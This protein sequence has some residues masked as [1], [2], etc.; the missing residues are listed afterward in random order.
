MAGN[1]WEWTGDWYQ[2]YPGS[3]ASSQFF[4]ERFRVTRGGGW[5]DEE[6]Q[7]R[8]TNRSS[9]DPAGANPDVG[10]RCAQ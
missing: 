9:A 7:V 2:A 8:A 5:F 3:S 1:V 10:F 6:K 4:G